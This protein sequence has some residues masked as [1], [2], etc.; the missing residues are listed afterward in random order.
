VTTSVVAETVVVVFA[1]F[2]IGLAGVAFARPPIAERFFSSFASSALTH[3]T[4]QAFRL[5]IGASL[6]VLS[7][8]MWQADL[9]R[10]TGWLVVVTSLGLLLMP[11]RWHH[12]FGQRVMPLVLRHIRLYAA[13]LIVFALLLLLGVFWGN[14]Y[15]VA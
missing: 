13:G 12:R 11:W 7:P 6:V 5:L 3:Y 8:K 4:E 10:I 2:L 9:F 1:L 14:S 15:V